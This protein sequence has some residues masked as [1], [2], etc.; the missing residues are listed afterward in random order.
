V[1]SFKRVLEGSFLVK[2]TLAYL[3]AGDAALVDDESGA[4]GLQWT[5]AAALALH[6]KATLLSGKT[7]HAT[8]PSVLASLW[9]LQS[10]AN[11]DHSSLTPLLPKYLQHMCAFDLKAGTAFLGQWA[12]NYTA[13]H[14][15]IVAAQLELL[16]AVDWRSRVTFAKDVLPCFLTL[17]VGESDGW[18]PT[19]EEAPAAAAAAEMRAFCAASAAREGGLASPGRSKWV[20]QCVGVCSDVWTKVAAGK[21]ALGK[22]DG[23]RPQGTPAKRRKLTAL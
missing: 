12:A 23:S 5:T 10:T 21:S 11:S 17:F 22:Q 4:S 1:L 7:F 20:L 19:L 2:S 6:I 8:V 3:E 16:Q 18:V 9:I 15:T 14:K 13:L